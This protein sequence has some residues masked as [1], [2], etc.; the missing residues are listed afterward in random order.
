M[1][2]QDALKLWLTAFPKDEKEFAE[3]FLNRFFEKN[4]RYIIKDCRLVTMLFLLDATLYSGDKEEQGKYLYAAATLPE[5]RGQG[6]MS[7]LIEKAKY[8]T[9]SKGE[10]LLTK[11][12]SSSLFEY[13][14]RFGFKT[15]AFAKEIPYTLKN[16]TAPLREITAEEYFSKRKAF[17]KN[18]PFIT[19]SDNAYA[20]KGL[21]L[22]GDENT[23][24]A[25]DILEAPPRVLE[26]GSN[27]RGG[28]DA[29]LCAINSKEALFYEED[30]T[31]FAMMIGGD[32]DKK[33]HF[34][35]AL[36]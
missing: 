15:V 34:T 22:F 19:L 27:T 32:A 21:T 25:V 31:P 1:Y 13:Y 23:F 6:L 26:F 9:A 2:K 8:E 18:D 20:Y 11:P 4:C 10:F 3:D 36:D 29:L 16:Q 30:T 5:Y 14:G 35:L 7:E 33:L 28:K 12:A 24:A 17:Y